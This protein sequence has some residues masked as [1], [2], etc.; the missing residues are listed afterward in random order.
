MHEAFL[1]PCQEK[2]VLSL[3]FECPVMLG[4]APTS[5]MVLLEATGLETNLAKEV[6]RNIESLLFQLAARERIYWIL[7]AIVVAHLQDVSYDGDAD[8]VY[9]DLSRCSIYRPR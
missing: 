9:D 4:V 3:A 5:R 8:V 6:A 1:A 7:M 2:L